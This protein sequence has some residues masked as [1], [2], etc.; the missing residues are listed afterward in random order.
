MTSPEWLRR[1]QMGHREQVWRE[2]RELGP[3]IRSRPE[4]AREA[5]LVCDEMAHRARQN[6]ETI[7][8]RLTADGYRF[9]S[10]DDDQ[11]SQTPHMPPTATA[12]DSAA[13]LEERFGDVP[14]TVL[15]WM[16]LVGDVWLVGTHPEWPASASGDPLVIEVEGSRH[17]GSSMRD[18]VIEEWEQW[19][20]YVD[21]GDAPGPFVL[22]VAPDQ[23]HK[24]NTSG[25]A[26]YGIILP[27]GSTDALFVSDTTTPFVSYLNYAFAHGGFPHETGS[28]QEQRIKAALALD[29]LPL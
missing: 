1:Y 3:A 29:L 18:Y 26:P 17:P 12:A 5:Q 22:P 7:I 6:V 11:I 28:P 20:E 13:W 14:M 4:L 2:L 27:D 8:E 10:N 16:R 9:H 24:E 19:Q 15:S 25:G 23:L 21:D